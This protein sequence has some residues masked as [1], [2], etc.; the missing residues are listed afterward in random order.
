LSTRAP[1]RSPA[2]SVGGARVL[3]LAPTRRA[4]AAPAGAPGGTCVAPP[5]P[6]AP[7][8]IR[9]GPLPVHLQRHQPLPGLPAGRRRAAAAPPAEPHAAAQAG[10]AAAGPAGELTRLRRC[11]PQASPARTAAGRGPGGSC[12]AAPAWTLRTRAAC[13]PAHPPALA[14][15]QVRPRA[16]GAPGG[17]E[18]AVAPGLPQRGLRGLQVR[19]LEGHGLAEQ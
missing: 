1:S 2:S 8:R 17:A 11:M 3:P 16:G 14:A 6:P 5:P 18:A 12:L 9:A 19:A 15:G 7:R 4:A 10:A 13:P